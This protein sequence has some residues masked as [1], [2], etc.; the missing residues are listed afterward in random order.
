MPT[1][2]DHDA[3]DA[4]GGGF[5]SRWSR[6][7]ALVR[8]GVPLAEPASTPPGLVPIE[9][10]PLATA[11]PELP[12]LPEVL[13][14]PVAPGPAASQE[15]AVPAPP[16]PTLADVAALNQDSDFS[17]F[18]VPGV[19]QGVKNAALKKLFAD[20]HFNVMDGLDTYIDDYGKAD[21]LPAGMLRQMA[22]SHALGLFAD[23]P[24]EPAAALVVPADR[25]ATVAQPDPEPDPDL[26]QDNPP[27]ENLDLR[28][29]PHDAAGP[30]SPGQGAGPAAGCEH[31]RD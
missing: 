24:P 12:R 11:A 20:P 6:R 31:R 18:V 22:Q 14:R 30:A 17:R 3:A 26:L 13:D 28:L 1:P 5:L 25:V 8:Q 2:P 7:K 27:D 10:R 29:Q 9:Q 19:D 16:A 23:E 21:P 15:A 4:D